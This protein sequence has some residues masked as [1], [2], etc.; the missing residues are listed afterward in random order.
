MGKRYFWLKLK[1]DFF[2]RKEV[3]KLRRLDGG[4]SLVVIYLRLLLLSVK[5]GGRVVFEGVEDS[6][7]EELGLELDEDVGGVG[8]VLDFCERYGLIERG[9]DGEFLL[10]DAATAIGSE[11]RSAE[12][13]RRF[14]EKQALHCNGDVTGVKRLCNEDV[15]LDIEIE[16]EKEI[17][18]EKEL[19]CG[20]FQDGLGLLDGSGAVGGSG[21][22]SDTAA[23]VSR[24][25]WVGAGERGSVG[26]SDGSVVEA[27]GLWEH[28]VGVVSPLLAERIAELVGEVGLGPFRRAVEKAVL[29]GK[30]NFAYVR[31]TAVGIAAGNDFDEQSRL[32]RG[33]RNDVVGAK[34]AVL[35]I[36]KGDG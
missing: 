3:K 7:A 5:C 29:R 30:R 25:G 23:G 19:D 2:D 13:V 34:N 16:K 6:L 11:S 36:L 22:G 15:T 4:D 14:R 21:V 28:E 18:L 9:S 27:Y 8:V 33:A 35:E 24:V 26:G 20:G 17:E 1:D 10:T 32:G 12:R 31:A